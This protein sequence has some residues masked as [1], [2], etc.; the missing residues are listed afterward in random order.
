M[1]R[2]NP[3]VKKGVKNPSYPVSYLMGRQIGN[4]A[5]NYEEKYPE[6]AIYEETAPN[7]RVWRTYEDESRFTMPTWSK[8]PGIML[9]FY[10]SS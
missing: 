5:Y 9:T 10:L 3:T 8:N 7:A 6:D 1:R 2:P 4:D